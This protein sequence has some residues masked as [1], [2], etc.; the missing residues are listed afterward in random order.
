MHQCSPMMQNLQ[1]FMW[2]FMWLE[3]TMG[4]VLPLQ[5]MTAAFAN[6]EN[7]KKRTMTEAKIDTLLQTNKCLK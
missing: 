1:P 2:D 4:A 5:K 3:E 7:K 6:Q